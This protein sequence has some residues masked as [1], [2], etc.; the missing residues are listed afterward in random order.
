MLDNCHDT[1]VYCSQLSKAEQSNKETGQMTNQIS[2]ETK[3][4]IRCQR[5]GCVVEQDGYYLPEN[6]LDDA[7]GLWH[8]EECRPIEHW[9]WNGPDD[10]YHET[11]AP[12]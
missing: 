7:D 9:K 1:M 5:C 8:C 6:W 4:H 11:D 12:I 2:K 10:G 3:I